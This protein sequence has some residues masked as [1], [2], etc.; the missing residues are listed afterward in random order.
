MA[1]GVLARIGHTWEIMGS[2]WFVLKQDRELLVFTALSGV[3]SLLVAA[4]FIAPLIFYG[5]GAALMQGGSFSTEAG[6]Y[7]WL[8]LFYFCNYFVITFFN[9]AVVGCAILRLGNNNPTLADG[10]H[11]A[12]KRI[13]EIAGWAMLSASIGVV[14]RM[15][16]ERSGFLGKLAAG[17]MGVAFTLASFLVV[18]V[19]VV[20]GLGPFAALKE[21]AHYIKETWGAQVVSNISYGAIFMFFALP[22]VAV[23]I[24]SVKIGGALLFFAGVGAL[25]LLLLGVIQ[26]TL[27]TIFQAAMYVYVRDEQ[28]P[29]GFTTNMLRNAM[30]NQ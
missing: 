11:I 8:L 10:F 2:C 27:Y 26:A 4:T 25:Y 15:I 5:Q 1:G 16:E 30:V 21:S 13:W 18:P 9:A 6:F 22:G 7:A 17:F 29:F 28:V 19:I 24:I 12:G 20:E 3:C 14:L 23:I